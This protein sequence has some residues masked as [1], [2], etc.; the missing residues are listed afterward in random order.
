M[1]RRG[2]ASE[3]LAAAV[4]AVAI[5]HGRLPRRGD[6][7]QWRMLRRI[8][9]FCGSSAGVA[10]AYQD[11]AREVGRLLGERAIHLVYGGG[12]VGL[13]G[14]VADACL[15]AGG[16]VTG[17]IPQALVDREVA[18]TGLTELRVVGSMH[19]R[20]ALMA[21]LSDAFM[22]LPGGY[23]TWDELFEAL[24]WSQ[25]GIQ[26]KACGLLNVDG[27][28][29]AMIAMVDRAIS[30]G[31]VHTAHR[32]LLHADTDVARLLERLNHAFVSGNPDGGRT[33]LRP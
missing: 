15:R 19:E 18:H 9:V 16:R 1:P 20:K 17:V 3:R 22:A 29:D 11:A 6:G 26:S 10:P 5:V 4:A 8:A 24:T 28:Y 33:A 25:L 21:E 32:A 12:R 27:Y 23:G 13:M 30:Q 7:L 14:G 31:F 2:L